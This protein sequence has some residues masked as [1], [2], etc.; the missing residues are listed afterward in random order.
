MIEES[1]RI[2]GEFP[3]VTE[4]SVRQAEE[5]PALPGQFLH[6]RRGLLDGSL[7]QPEVLIILNSFS[8][9]LPTD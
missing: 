3:A 1:P 2:F 5:R 8:Q 7:E 9:N 4:D 6:A